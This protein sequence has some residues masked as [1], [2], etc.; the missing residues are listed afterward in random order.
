MDKKVSILPNFFIVGAAKAGTTSL[1]HYLRQHP[2]V[3][4]PSIKET[5]FFAGIH[6]KDFLGPGS[7]YGNSIVET[8]E[9]YLSL[10]QDAYGKKAIGE[11]CVAYLY[12]KESALRIYQKVP[13]AR[14]IIILRNP[15]D[16]AYS[17]YMHHVRDGIEDLSF[18]E[19]IQVEDERKKQGYWWGFRYIDVGF[20][21][22]QVKRYFDIFGKE[23]VHVY[24]YE[25]FAKDPVFVL[26]AIMRI[27]EVNESFVPAY[28]PVYNISGKPR[29]RIIQSLLSNKFIRRCGAVL[30][31]GTR[32]LIRARVMEWNLK[33]E[34]MRPETRKYLANIYKDDIFMLEKLIGIKVSEI[35][36]KDL[37]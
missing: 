19:A 28:M 6:K 9:D 1:Y 25:D 31:K 5:F 21:Y 8:W 10:F 26:R 32:H 7:F 4:L 12:F 20:Y 15:I 27:L 37:V 14:I 13:N 36:L 34:P 17:N 16:R 29:S 3:F 18:E 22:E 33:K 11:V 2:E 35:W 23:Q 30:P 24:L